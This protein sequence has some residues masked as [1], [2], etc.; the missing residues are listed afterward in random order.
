MQSRKY[1]LH[2]G[3]HAVGLLLKGT[4]YSAYNSE[5]KYLLSF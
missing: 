1:L 2:S 4:E 3:K 5:R